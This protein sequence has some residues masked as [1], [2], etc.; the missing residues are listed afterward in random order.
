MSGL[1]VALGPV[2]GGWLLEHFW[3]GSMFLVNIP[4]VVV[5][6][7]LGRACVPDLHGPRGRAARPGRP[8]SCRSLRSCLLVFTVIEAPRTGWTSGD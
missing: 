7:V 5:A 8:A 3:W 6:L 4:I 1:A 2:T